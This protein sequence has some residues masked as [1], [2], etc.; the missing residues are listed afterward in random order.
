MNSQPFTSDR[1]SSTQFPLGAIADAWPLLRP[2]VR[3]TI[4]TLID[5]ELIH[6]RLR[7]TATDAW[8]DDPLEFDDESQ[9]QP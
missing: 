4:V 5:A 1:G 8:R 6:A 3:E 2:H 9:Q 7:Q